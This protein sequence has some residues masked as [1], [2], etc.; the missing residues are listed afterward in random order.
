MLTLESLAWRGAATSEAMLRVAVMEA[1]TFMLIKVEP[2]RTQDST[3][4]ENNRRVTKEERLS[5]S[6]KKNVRVKIAENICIW[7]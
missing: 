2:T 7:M 4:S 6:E 3:L 1:E 5:S